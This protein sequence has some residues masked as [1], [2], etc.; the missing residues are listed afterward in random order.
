V[1]HIVASPGWARGIQWL[2]ERFTIPLGGEHFRRRPRRTAEAEGFLVDRAE[3]RKLGV[4]E[5]VLL[6]KPVA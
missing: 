1:D 4:V 6:R 3:R 2:L 5:R